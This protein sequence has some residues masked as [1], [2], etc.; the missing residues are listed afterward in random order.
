MSLFEFRR[1]AALLGVHWRD[2]SREP[3]RVERNS[4]SGYCLEMICADFLAGAHFESSNEDTL[5]LALTRLIGALAGEQKL[6]MLEMMREDVEQIPQKT[7]AA[8]A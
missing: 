4:G 8:T 6:R 3:R 5:F 1:S 7:A 2:P